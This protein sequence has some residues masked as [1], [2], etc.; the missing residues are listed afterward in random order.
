MND[1]KSFLASITIW[2]AI[3]AIV[4]GGVTLWAAVDGD[5][6]SRT[7]SGI[8]GL[9]SIVG[10]G[11]S[12][13]GRVR[14][15]KTIVSVLAIVLLPLLLLSAC[16]SDDGGGGSGGGGPGGVDSHG[17]LVKSQ[18]WNPVTMMCEPK[19]RSP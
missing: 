19:S 3:A 6:L 17:C 14:A 18:R 10:G 13:Y 8:M 4:G 9:L 11:F 1:V 16:A 12:V 2:G 5:G 7:V 15:T